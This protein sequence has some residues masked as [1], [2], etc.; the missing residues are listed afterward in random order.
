MD[1]PR[2][3]T[4]AMEEVYSKTKHIT[5]YMLAA[6]SRIALICRCI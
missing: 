6:K 4:A 2:N 1:A 5:G 3:T